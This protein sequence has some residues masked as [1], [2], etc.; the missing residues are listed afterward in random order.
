MAGVPRSTA[1][2]WPAPVGDERDGG[3]REEHDC[4]YRRKRPSVAPKSTGR[5]QRRRPRSD[6][7]A[8]HPGECHDGA[9]VAG[10]HEEAECPSGNSGSR[11]VATTSGE[12]RD[13]KRRCG[14]EHEDPHIDEDEPEHRETGH[15]R[16]DVECDRGDR[17]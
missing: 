11:N 2:G 1:H 5:R 12:V 6:R 8:E 3:A 7:H 14:S 10:E 9:S 4:E 16:D 13:E 15:E 17:R